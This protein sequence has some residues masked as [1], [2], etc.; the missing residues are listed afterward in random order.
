MKEYIKHIFRIAARD[1]FTTLLVVIMLLGLTMVYI[2]ARGVANG[3][4][5]DCH[6]EP[7][8]K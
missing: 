3:S 2:K 7:E 1:F 5:L 4:T 8:K 6:W